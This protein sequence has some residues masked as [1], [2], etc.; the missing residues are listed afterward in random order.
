MQALAIIV[1]SVGG[2]MDDLGLSRLITKGNGE[3]LKT[4]LNIHYTK[5]S[6]I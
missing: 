1:H 2:E 6:R 4:E 3:A 5:E